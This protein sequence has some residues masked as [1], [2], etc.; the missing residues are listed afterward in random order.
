MQGELH[1]YRTKSITCRITHG[2][3][4]RGKQ[5][6]HFQ[7]DISRSRLLQCFEHGHCNIEVNQTL[8]AGLLTQRAGKIGIGVA[9][10]SGDN[11]T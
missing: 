8:I 6:F 7:K 3:S 1:P 4:Y 10:G 2:D 5:P 9:S 11:A